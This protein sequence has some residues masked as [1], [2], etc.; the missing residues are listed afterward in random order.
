MASNDEPD[1]R[2][3]TFVP[4]Y[5]SVALKGTERA[6][7][8]H[9]HLNSF[10][11][12]G[13]STPANSDSHPRISPPLGNTSG[14]CSGSNGVPTIVGSGISWV[15][16]KPLGSLWLLWVALRIAWKSPPKVAPGFLAAL[17]YKSLGVFQGKAREQNENK[18]QHEMYYVILDPLL[19]F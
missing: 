1:S 8:A 9:R 10:S 3:C 16:S 11:I 5:F 14:P 15:S 2:N 18:I 19:R 17:S 7:I 13:I 6:L 4:P 12:K